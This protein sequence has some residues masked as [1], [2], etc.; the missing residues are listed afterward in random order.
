MLRVVTVLVLVFSITTAQK[1]KICKQCETDLKPVCGKDGNTYTSYCRLR[2]KECIEDKI[3]GFAC[4][5]KCPCDS[6][7][8][9][10]I[11]RKTVIEL[12]NLRRNHQLEE[13]KKHDTNNEEYIKLDVLEDKDVTDKDIL[14][15]I[16]EKMFRKQEIHLNSDTYYKR[17]SGNCPTEEMSELPSRLIDWFHV[18]KTT[19]KEEEM[20]LEGIEKEPV[21]KEMSFLDAKLK[22]MYSVL[23]CKAQD[24][25]DL[26]KQVCLTPVKWMFHHLD[27]NKDDALSAVELYEIEQINNEHCIKPFLR[28]CDTNQDGKVVLKEF[29]Q[30]LCLTPPCTKIMQAVPTILLRGEPKPMPGLFTP[31][32]DEDGFFM[33]KQ[34]NKKRGDCWCVDRNGAEID[35]TRSTEEIDCDVNTKSLKKGTKTIPL[36]PYK[37][38][39]SNKILE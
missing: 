3:I 12:N 34:C 27:T 29:C 33:P 13:H 20:K 9:Y 39:A 25:K 21:L 35:G 16:E 17:G 26:E 24:D 30:C 2:Q 36:D 23:A 6:A 10:N 31:K 28:D 15:E 38:N 11:D 8:I 7:E 1:L 37:E 19:E 14:D 5:G 18:L 22:S 4:D 32:C